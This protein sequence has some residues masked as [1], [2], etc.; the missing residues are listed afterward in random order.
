MNHESPHM[1]WTPEE[2]CQHSSL[3]RTIGFKWKNI[4]PMM[5]GRTANQIKNR[6]YSV[7]AK[8]ELKLWGVPLRYN[9]SHHLHPSS[10]MN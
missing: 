9:I 4:A 6:W 2:D 3:G 7:S 8:R 10:K 1:T 5:T